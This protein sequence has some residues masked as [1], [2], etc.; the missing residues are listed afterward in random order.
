MF[1]RWNP[2]SELPGFKD[3]HEIIHIRVTQRTSRTYI[4]SIEGLNLDIDILKDWLK[5]VKKILCC[6]GYI[7]RDNK[8]VLPPRLPKSK[9]TFPK[10]VLCLSGDQRERCRDLIIKHL[11]ISID[12]IKIH[13]F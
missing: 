13:G 2:E 7:Q 9:T 12:D 6:N 5:K 11:N 10:E 8:Q 3:D 4:T 1:Q